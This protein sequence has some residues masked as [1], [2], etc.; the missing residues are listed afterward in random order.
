MWSEDVEA[1]LALVR[2][3]IERAAERA[4]RDP[5]SIEI[6]P[7]TKGHPVAGIEI[8]RALGLGAIGENRVAEAEE[9]RA[10]LG[11]TPGL[12]WHMIGRLQ[13]NKARR[14]VRTFDVIESVDSLRLAETLGRM[15]L[16]EAGETPLDVLVQVNTSGEDVKAGFHAG[17]A[18]EAVAEV[19]RVRGL[20]VDGLMTMAPYTEDEGVLRRT[21]RGARELLDRCRDEVSGFAG[22]TLSMGMSNDFELAVEEGSTRLRLGTV[23]LG[24]R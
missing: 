17:E 19:C 14:A 5:G 15:A 6:L 12:R 2:E 4:G 23:I 20:R 13:R 8:V 24:V 1:R 7:V 11:D 9:K 3:R 16:E 10:E 18:V 22:T 21:F